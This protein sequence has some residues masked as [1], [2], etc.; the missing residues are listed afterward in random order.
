MHLG[1][2]LAPTPLYP[3][4]AHPTDGRV[5]PAG[6]RRWMLAA[7]L[8]LLPGGASP[9]RAAS[10]PEPPTVEHPGVAGAFTFRLP[11]DWKVSGVPERKV[12]LEAVGPDGA[13]VR[14]L[15]LRS[16]GGLDSLHSTCMAEHLVSPM[17]VE[18]IGPY[19][20]DFIGRPLQGRAS[21]D[22]AFEVLYDAPILG[23]RRWRQRNLTMVGQGESLCIAVHVPLRAWKKG[24]A[25]RR[26]LD[27]VV[28]SVSFKPRP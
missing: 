5:F 23:E 2:L 11:P 22:S 21:L 3:R 17:D 9:L 12:Q 8:T 6:P 18:R 20:Y 19:E 7:A 15:H 28:T 14:F 24:K 16:E 25:L 1:N 4:P 26:R 27:A 13:V 10:P